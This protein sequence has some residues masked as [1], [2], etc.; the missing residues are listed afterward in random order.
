MDRKKQDLIQQ[1]SPE[2]LKRWSYSDSALSLLNSFFP[3]ADS[4]CVGGCGPLAFALRQLLP[5]SMFAGVVKN[6][7][8]EHLGVMH[9]GRFWDCRGA[10][11]PRSVER[12]WVGE[13][14]NGGRVTTLTDEQAHQAIESYGTNIPEL[15]ETVIGE[16]SGENNSYQKN[17]NY[18]LIF[19]KYTE[20]PLPSPAAFLQAAEASLHAD[21]NKPFVGRDDFVADVLARLGLADCALAGEQA[22]SALNALVAQENPSGYGEKIDY[23][24]GEAAS[25]FGEDEPGFFI[26]WPVDAGPQHE[27]WA[28]VQGDYLPAETEVSVERY[29]VEEAL[30]YLVAPIS[31][32]LGINQPYVVFADLSEDRRLALFVDGTESGFPIFL[33][34]PTLTTEPE[35]ILTSLLHELAHAY[36]RST[37]VVYTPEEEDIAEAFGRRDMTV[38]AL[39]QFAVDAPKSEDEDWEDEDWE[40]NPNLGTAREVGE[41]LGVDWRTSPFDVGQFARRLGGH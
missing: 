28:D 30:P 5:G 3:E 18:E 35:E 33:I 8:V 16:L 13:F 39:E 10:R 29:I 2:A 22:E 11:L 12:Y 32:Q 23:E 27:Q 36:L 14:C 7:V 37:G 26:F 34:D 21:W 24:C 19:D 9:D 15:I 31:V 40:E 41:Y 1:L 20:N 25:V 38:S 6:G 4:W 17:P